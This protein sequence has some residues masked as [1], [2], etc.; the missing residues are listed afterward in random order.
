MVVAAAAEAAVYGDEEPRSV[1]GPKFGRV[2]VGIRDGMGRAGA[3][4]EQEQEPRGLGKDGCRGER[5]PS[6]G[7]RVLAAFFVAAC[8][9][10][11]ACSTAGGSCA[12]KWA[13]RAALDMRASTWGGHQEDIISERVDESGF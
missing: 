13:G 6:R 10:V 11:F 1:L 3:A 12:P 2:G 8:A 7:H 5:R 4:G 9:V